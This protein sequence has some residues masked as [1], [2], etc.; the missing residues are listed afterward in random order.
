MITPPRSIS[1][2]PRLTRA[3]PVCRSGTEPVYLASA[4]RPLYR[5][6]SF[7][8]VGFVV[9][10]GPGVSSGRLHVDGVVGGQ[11]LD[12]GAA[13]AQEDRQAVRV[14]VVRGLLAVG[15]DPAALP[16]PAVGEDPRVALTDSLAVRH[17]VVLRELH[18]DVRGRDLI[19]A[20]DEVGLA[21]LGPL[22]RTRVG[23]P[24]VRRVVPG[25]EP[26]AH[27]RDRLTEVGV[28]RRWHTSVAS[29]ITPAV[30]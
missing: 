7:F 29:P 8:P 1:A 26:D 10:A 28:G 2:S 16:H 3:V 12:P 20:D 13:R 25:E 30:M 14:D 9:A 5:A 27:A 18:H 24:V 22:P 17:A 19:A 21:L 6:A 4:M 11:E 15:P 23:I